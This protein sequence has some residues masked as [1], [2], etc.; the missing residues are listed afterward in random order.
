[1]LNIVKNIKK[2][3][4]GLLAQKHAQRQ[5]AVSINLKRIISHFIEMLYE[6]F[7]ISCMYFRETP[8]TPLT[9]L[10]FS[11]VGG[12]KPDPPNNLFLVTVGGSKNSSGGVQPPQPPRQLPHCLIVKRK[13]GG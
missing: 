5:L 13:E 6:S 7:H 2:S 9:P 10:H 8:L 1:M 4:V 12:S 11:P 3:A